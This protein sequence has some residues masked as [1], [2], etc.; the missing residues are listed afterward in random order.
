M[1]SHRDRVDEK[2]QSISA[3][4]VRMGNVAGEMVRLSVEAVLSG[5]V[6]LARHVMEMD[7]EV[8][9]LE[10]ETIQRI[11]VAVGM[12]SPVAADLRLLTSSL[13][14]IGE[15]EKCADDAVKLSRRA[16]KLV[17]HFPGEM[18]LALEQMG[19]EARK[20]LN[21]ALKLYMEYD[22]ELADSIIRQDDVVDTA[23]VAA[24][25]RL[26][27]LIQKDP[28]ETSHLVR[29]IEAFHALEHVADHA[30]E[31]AARLKLYYGKSEA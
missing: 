7:D 21:M 16:T 2:H 10:K 22:E 15:M 12:E 26:F 13:G 18:K 11:V 27:E 30:A 17:G 14:I 5:D 23:Y 31:V 25:N 24:R 8:D 6:G 4:I 1:Q 3:A 19:V 29:A 9:D 28:S 20:A